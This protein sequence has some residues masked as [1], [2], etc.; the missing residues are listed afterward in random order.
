MWFACRQVK[1]VVV[2]H[3]NIIEANRV[4]ALVRTVGEGLLHKAVCLIMCTFPGIMLRMH[5]VDSSWLYPA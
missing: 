1:P 3:V 4:N 5:K 2:F